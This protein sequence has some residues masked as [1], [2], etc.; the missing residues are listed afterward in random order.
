MEKLERLCDVV[1]ELVD[2]DLCPWKGTG[3][4]PLE[5]EVHRASLVLADR[6]CGAT[7]DPIIR[8]TQEKR[9]KNALR[10]WLETHGYEHITSKSISAVEKMRPGTFTFGY[11]ITVAAD[12][13]GETNIPVDGLIMPKDAATDDL[14]MIVEAKSAGDP[15]N[16]NKRKKEEVRRGNRLQEEF[17]S[18]VEFVLFLCGYF[19]AGDLGTFAS[20]SY[21]LGMGAP[22]QRSRRVWTRRR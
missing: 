3:D 12:T 8:N 1:E 21:R 18:D 4:E 13:E 6:L 2:E 10:E 20:E 15:V 17:G 11:T 5:E 9:Q 7:R 22:H 19:G 16:P 14:P